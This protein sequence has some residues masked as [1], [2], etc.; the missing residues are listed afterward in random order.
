MPHLESKA[1]TQELEIGANLGSFLPWVMANQVAGITTRLQ[2]QGFDFVSLLPMR[3]TDRPASLPVW[4]LEK[5]WNPTTHAGLGGLLDVLQGRMSHDPQAP[6]LQDWIAFPDA[7][8]SQ[9]IFQEQM[10]RYGKQAYIVKHRLDDPYFSH[11]TGNVRLRSLLEVNP[12]MTELHDGSVVPLTLDRLVEHLERARESLATG[13]PLEFDG[14]I[15]DQL[16]GVVFDT[17]HTRRRTRE[18]EVSRISR[19]GMPTREN[20]GGYKQVSEVLAPHIRLIDFQG[21]NPA[22]LRAT[23]NNQSTELAD[24]IGELME[25]LPGVPIRLE[26]QLGSMEHLVPGAV[27]TQM[28]EA[29]DFVRGVHGQIYPENSA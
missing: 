22:E 25:T 14:W 28:L 1:P 24:M 4:F 10:A 29:A 13:Q 8:T 12:G 15:R 16:S 20:L 18:D 17:K 2:Q 21:L 5:A 7:D 19:S 26:I 6:H 3:N 11:E 9:K 23:L 27:M